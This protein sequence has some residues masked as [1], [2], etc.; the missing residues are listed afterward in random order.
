MRPV[1]AAYPATRFRRARRTEALRRLTQE[2]TLSVNDLIWPVFVRDGAGLREPV[3][4][5]PGVERLSLDQVVRAAEMA[6]GLG[7]PAI[8]LFPYTDPAKKTEAC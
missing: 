7:I 4:S 1:Q 5:M 2:H 8:C 6:A 3:P